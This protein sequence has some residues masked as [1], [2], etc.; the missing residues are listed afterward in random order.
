MK[1]S[2]MGR[3]SIGYGVAFA[4]AALFGSV[5]HGA[6]LLGAS[7]VLALAAAPAQASTSGMHADFAT[8][9][10][11]EDSITYSA[12]GLP[13]WGAFTV[14]IANDAGNNIP[15][16]RFTFRTNKGTALKVP[17][18]PP[19]GNASATCAAGPEGPTLIICQ[20]TTAGSPLTFTLQAAS[21]LP[22]AAVVPGDQMTIVWTVQTSQGSDANNSG[23]SNTGNGVINLVAGSPT[24]L[25]GYVDNDT[26]LTVAD[27]AGTQTKVRP[28]KP[29]TAALKQEVSLS[30]CSPQFKVCLRSTTT[31]ED[32]DGVPITFDPPLIIDLVRD[33]STMKKGAK[34]ANLTL[35]YTPKNGVP[36]TIN[37]CVLVAGVWTWITGDRCVVPA[38]KPAN[39][40][41]YEDKITGDWH[42]QVRGSTNGQ[43]DW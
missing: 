43:I 35:T 8:A 19:N 1:S 7:A 20:V 12:Q 11:G 40:F 37:E 33:A 36:Y 14:T 27:A 41:T 13:V 39:A 6:F 4:G 29:A 21:P 28:S 34:I 22:P 23:I 10:T 24:E 31:I 3:R 16:A 30:S 2:K 15:N 18:I 42:I 9:I 17:T 38:T 25:R 5:R 26:P 32:V